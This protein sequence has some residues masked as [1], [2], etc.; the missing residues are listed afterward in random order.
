MSYTT[1]EEIETEFGASNVAQW[2]D[3]DNNED[4]GAITA[5]VAWSIAKA[6]RRIDHE[7]A[8][9]YETPLES[10]T[11]DII[12]DIATTLAGVQLAE[13]PRGLVDGEGE[14]LALRQLEKKALEMLRDLA[15]GRIALTGYEPK[16][17][18]Y[19]AAFKVE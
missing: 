10:E 1:R 2:A 7:L 3:A 9:R 11:P 14:G 12:A 19:P 6:S 8:A 13:S 5:R 18:N 17:T 16:F 4:A 15:T